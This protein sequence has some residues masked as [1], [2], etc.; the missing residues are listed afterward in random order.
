M[1]ML[2]MSKDEPPVLLR[3]ILCGTLVVPVSWEENVRLAGDNNTAGAGRTM[4]TTATDLGLA[5]VGNG[6][7]VMGARP[8]VEESML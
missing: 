4:P 8:P 7:P 2:V 1:V 6:E 3:V 5:P